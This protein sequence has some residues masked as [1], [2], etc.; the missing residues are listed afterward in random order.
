MSDDT[1]DSY[2]ELI[3]NHSDDSRMHVKKAMSWALRE[4][5]KMNHASH[6]KALLTAHD[7]C[8]DSNKNRNWIGKTSLKELNQLVSINERQRLISSKTK[9]G[10]AGS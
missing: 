1:I 2:L 10:K 9:M 3:K 6:E 7:F 4:I 5:G 8:D